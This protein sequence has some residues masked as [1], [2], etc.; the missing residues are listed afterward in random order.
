MPYTLVG[1]T[2][3]TLLL[4]STKQRTGLDPWEDIAGGQV[5]RGSSVEDG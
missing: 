1:R 4:P 2:E 3:R 5:E